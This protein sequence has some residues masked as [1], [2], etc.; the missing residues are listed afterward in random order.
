MHAA[1]LRWRRFASQRIRLRGVVVRA[2]AS[3]LRQ[4]RRTSF[5]QWVANTIASSRQHHRLLSMLQRWQWQNLH[6]CF[7]AW[8]TFVADARRRRPFLQKMCRGHHRRQLRTCVGTWRRYCTRRGTLRG[9]IQHGLALI[10]S[11]WAKRKRCALQRALSQQWGRTFL[12]ASR[13]QDADADA[14]A[15]AVS[16]Q[17][18]ALAA[19]LLRQRRD[20]K[21]QAWRTIVAWHHELTKQNDCHQKALRMWVHRLT[22]RAFESWHFV[23]WES[24]RLRQILARTARHLKNLKIGTTWR[25]WAS[26]MRRRRDFRRVVTSQSIRAARA[27]QM[28]GWKKWQRF[29]DHQRLAQADRRRGCTSMFRVLQRMRCHV[30][31]EAWRTWRQDLLETAR[32]ERH[33]EHGIAR[34]LFGKESKAFA[35]WRHYAVESKRVRKVCRSISLRVQHSAALKAFS[36]WQRFHSMCRERKDILARTSARLLRRGMQLQ[37][38]AIDR[39][40]GETVFWRRLQN[41]RKEMTA[42]AQKRARDE[43]AKLAADAL[44]KRQAR[45]LNF[46]VR[47]CCRSAF[48]KWTHITREKKRLRRVASKVVVHITQRLLRQACDAWL[49][50]TLRRKRIHA[51]VLE[52]ART[53]VKKRLHRGWLIWSGTFLRDARRRESHEVAALYILFSVVRQYHKYRCARALETWR[54]LAKEQAKA[55]SQA[56]RAVSQWQTRALRKC[57]KSWQL[58]F[59]VWQRQR[60]CCERSLRKMRLLRVHRALFS[61]RSFVSARQHLRS[62]CG[63]IL[64]IHR[65]CEEERLRQVFYHWNT[66]AIL[67]ERAVRHALL[68]KKD[69]FRREL[70][71]RLIQMRFATSRSIRL[72]SGFRQLQ[73]KTRVKKAELIKKHRAVQVLYRAISFISVK[74]LAKAWQVRRSARVS[75]TGF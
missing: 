55:L 15:L 53:I 56:K 39:W 5:H 16:A 59:H 12:W 24:I 32:M 49:E 57:L 29:C 3:G 14:R 66:T 10:E 64:G 50:F 44:D 46:W 42:V 18:R 41:T 40:R 31:Q 48:M 23:V 30:L 27:R 13:T 43:K 74:S 73:E 75:V 8:E 7:G 17:R 26:F 22:L 20:D 69:D 54:L 45:A 47:L 71:I 28:Q 21:R 9:R 70:F 4:Q 2:L 36:S 19:L 35:M 51:F 33:L 34:F 67:I 58:K 63:R 68:S 61:W 62:L 38:A 25:T 11:V 60:L 37:Q 1:M 52:R 65:R 6:A 72:V